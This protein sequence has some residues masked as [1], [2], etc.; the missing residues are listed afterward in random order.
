LAKRAKQK[1][2]GPESES[3]LS[4]R[5]FH[6]DEFLVKEQV[7][8]LIEEKLD[9]EFRSTNF[10]VIDGNALDIGELASL[11]STPSLFGGD[12]VILVDQTSAFAARSD[13]RK[14]SGRVLES[15]KRGDRGAALR[16]FAQLLQV[17]G[18]EPT[19]IE[20]GEDWTN[21]VLGQSSLPAERDAL[22]Q[23]GQAF[24]EAGIKSGPRGD[25]DQL[26]ELIRSALPQGTL[27]IFTAAEV[28]KRKKIFKTLE[29]LGSVVH[30]EVRQ[31][32]LRVAMD[33]QFFEERV[34]RFLHESGKRIRPDA[35]EKMY[36]RSGKDLRQLHSELSKLVGYLGSRE[37]ILGEDVTRV[38][39]DSHE[40]AFFELNRVIRSGDVS[41]CLTALHE[42]LKIVAHPLQT[43]A[44]IANEFRKLM[45]AREL[46]FTVFRPSWKSG[47][48]FKAFTPI[49]RQIREDR[50]ELT[51]QG[52]FNLLA[53]NDYVL[54][55]MLGDAQRF[56]LERL[57]RIVERI[58][59]ADVMMKSTRVGS[60]S[61]EMIM[62]DLVLFICRPGAGLPR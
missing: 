11:V 55:L 25:E 32:K 62:E 34:E 1:A 27:L 49:L 47:M 20:H 33:R 35:L 23:V 57:I 43:L 40:V 4:V 36:A 5:L 24:L 14:I 44:S 45:V 3:N 58:L 30:C 56:P 22:I 26:E 52:K 7:Q 8:K 39:M 59:E 60:R 17:A 41:R 12:R 46:L 42:N 18:I 6:G 53:M 61:P 51:K 2:T 50:P 16:A 48:T 10:I 21:E 13:Q 37:E 31:D 19:D 29:S 9:P 15:W 54:Y 28:D 38:F